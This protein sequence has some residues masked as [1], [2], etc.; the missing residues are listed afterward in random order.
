[1][2]SHRPI[3]SGMCLVRSHWGIENEVHW[4]LDVTFRKDDSRLRRGNGEENFAVL[5]HITLN[6]LKRENSAKGSLKAKRKKAT[7][8]DDYL[9]RVLTG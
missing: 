8:D 1:M 6:L 4:V 9:L 3:R 5:R 7:W 2:G